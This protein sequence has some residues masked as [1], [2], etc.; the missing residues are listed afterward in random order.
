MVT[1]AT[2]TQSVNNSREP[3]FVTCHSNQRKPRRPTTSMSAM[4]IADLDQ[5]PGEGRPELAAAPCA[6]GR[7]SAPASGGSTTSTSTIAKSSTTSQPTAIRPFPSRAAPRS[8]SAFSR[9]TVLATDRDEAEDERRR[10][11]SQPQERA[12]RHRR[13]PWPPSSARR[14]RA[15][16]TLRTARRSA[17]EKWRPTPN[18]SSMTPISAS[19]RRSRRRRRSPAWRAR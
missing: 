10:R 7:P 17:S 16:A 15:A 12:P 6:R 5:G 13:A 1:A 3:V 9:T 2:I 4:N 19:W 18:I 11:A 8:S 14:R